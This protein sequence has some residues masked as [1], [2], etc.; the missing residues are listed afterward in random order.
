MARHHPCAQ[1]KYRSLRKARGTG[2]EKGDLVDPGLAEPQDAG[3]GQRKD[4]LRTLL[5]G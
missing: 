1:V 5:Q 4:L 3:R 2:D